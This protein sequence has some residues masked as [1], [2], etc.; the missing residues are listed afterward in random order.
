M[1]A[2]HLKAELLY[3]YD[4]D[5]CSFHPLPLHG[6]HL[7]CVLWLVYCLCFVWM[8]D[9][10]DCL[11]WFVGLAAQKALRLELVQ[12]FSLV[13]ALVSTAPVGNV[14]HKVVNVQ[15]L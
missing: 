14:L 1:V 15:E 9:Q 6:V 7:L 11:G 5:C 4:G 12:D 3:D 2:L 10:T 8:T 13:D